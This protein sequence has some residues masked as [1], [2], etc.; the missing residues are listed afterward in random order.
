MSNHHFFDSQLDP[1]KAQQLLHSLKIKPNKKLGQN[2]LVDKNIAAKL[3]SV[4]NL[5]KETDEILEVGPGL[6]C[7]TS[8]LVKNTKKVHAIELDKRLYR[9]L[10]DETSKNENLNLI[11]GDVLKIEIPSHNKVVSNI[12]Y[13]ITG[14]LLSKLLFKSNAPE[15]YMIIEKALADRIM[16]QPNTEAFSRLSVSVK[17]FAKPTIIQKIQ[18]KCFYPIPKIELTMIKLIPHGKID[19]FFDLEE[20]IKLFLNL[21]RG[22]FPYKNKDSV[23]A[24]YLYLKK[25]EVSKADTLGLLKSSQKSKKIRAFDLN[26]FFMIAKEIESQGLLREN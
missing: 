13:T 1:F 15:I 11:L 9:F 26:D 12:P 19:E 14:P 2:F 4:A 25:F 22:I 17:T 18:R 7:L 10:K 6:G 8:L 3:I 23:N 21:L 20:N 5:S 16:A 24:L